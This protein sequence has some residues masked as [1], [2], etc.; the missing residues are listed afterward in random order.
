MATSSIAS[1]AEQPFNGLLVSWNPTATAQ[2][3]AAARA[4]LGLGLQEQI[5]TSSMKTHGAGPID[6]VTLPPGLDA[7]KALEILSRRPGVQFV[8]KNWL[9]TT[10]AS[11]NDPYVTSNQLWG[12]YG[13]Q[14]SP[15][16]PFGSQAA[17]VW[18]A[19]YT[20]SSSVY[21]GIIDEGY[22][23]SH[24]DLLANAG[25]NPGEIAGDGKDNDGNGYIDDVYGWD[26]FSNNASVYDG[27][28]DDHGTHV[29]GTI[30]AK[31]GNG[32]GVA[33]VAWD[34]KLLSGKFLGPNGGYISD[35]IKA[36]DYFTD[37]KTRQG[38]KIVATNN[39]W[40]GGG[41]SQGLYDA[42]SRANNAGIL[43]VAA[44]GNNGTSTLSYPAGYDLPNV[45][46]VAAIDSAG[47]LASFSNYSSSWVDLGAAGVGINSTLPDNTYGAYS[48]TSMATPHVTGA[49]ALMAAA[50]PQAS[51]T[52]LRNA[53]LQSAVATPSLSGKTSTGGRLDV[54]AALNLLGQQFNSNSPKYTLTAPAAIN[55]SQQLAINITT[56]NVASGSV[57]TWKLSG[58]GIEANDFTTPELTGSIQV[59]NDGKAAFQKTI[60]SDELI[61][62]NETL[63]FELSDTTNALV[64][65]SSVVINDLN[66]LWG[67]RSSDTITGVNQRIE[68][69]SGVLATGTALEDLGKGQVDVVTGGRGPDRFLL[70]QNRSGSLRVFYS[71]GSNRNNGTTD[72][73]RIT[74][75]NLAED[76]L[77]FGGGSYFSRNS[78]ND[79]QIWWDRNNNGNLNISNNQ[80]SSDELIALVSGVNL[81]F[82]TITASTP[83]AY[84]IFLG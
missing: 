12:M 48:G 70:S 83:Q 26:F 13:D 18:A 69:I 8:E 33:G 73:L 25:V 3:R 23:Y 52:D 9:L 49:V 77:Q 43:F 63:L 53:L 19:G 11:S 39:S 61:E 64:A 45:I 24:S 82:S 4:A 34:V 84:G 29:A 56:Q 17:E 57:L 55:E 65:S 15:A 36:V 37:L 16:N 41:F 10:Q 58:T 51:S 81:G 54:M 66:S 78:G 76:K 1:T 62:G 38:L 59:G 40:G 28:T 5:Q 2:I 20:G 46:S 74:D 44:A 6:W 42:I 50:F 67:S 75:F 79:T 7:T 31:G 47:G 68:Q 60:A 14:S 32:L 22:Q 30:G 35:A 27:T 80:N 71:D 21:V 72:Y